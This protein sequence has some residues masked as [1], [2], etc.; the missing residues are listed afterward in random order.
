MFV[1]LS[2]YPQSDEILAGDVHTYLTSNPTG[3]SLCDYS[4]EDATEI[5]GDPE[6]FRYVV[7]RD[8][9]VR[10]V[11]GYVD[12]FILYPPP[13]P[14]GEPPIVIGTVIDW[15]YERRGETPDYK[16]S[17]TFEEFVSH[18]FESEDGILDTHFKSQ[19]CYLEHQNRTL[20]RKPLLR[21][22]GQEKLLPAQL[23]AQRSLPHA[24]ELL[25]D[26]LAEHLKSRYA[27]DYELWQEALA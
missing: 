11:S 1:R 27:T 14:H 23:N 20:R 6:Y 25:T 9:L 4:P 22:R 10:A 16:R 13:G 3:L 8:P 15:V 17:I 18:L 26:E 24:S 2:G 19:Q 5:L 12:K 7:L 21:R